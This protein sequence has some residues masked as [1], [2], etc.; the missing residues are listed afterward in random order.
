MAL[1]SWGAS[2]GKLSPG[3]A[4]VCHSW[5]VADKWQPIGNF[6][7]S[8][9]MSLQ[10][11]YIM[12]SVCAT[13]TALSCGLRT[14]SPRFSANLIFGQFKASKIGGASSLPDLSASVKSG[15]DLQSQ[16]CP[17]SGSEYSRSGCNIQR[18]SEYTACW[19]M[20][21][22]ANQGQSRHHMHHTTPHVPHVIKPQLLR[23]QDDQLPFRALGS[24]HQENS[25]RSSGFTSSTSRR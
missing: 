4:K 8:L 17:S 5:D 1:V 3:A 12:Q 18:Y 2:S 6:D 25:S 13:S 22:H 9:Y 11:L 15:H 20:L 10:H 16:P 21:N 19:R 14:R 23:R 7:L 24:F